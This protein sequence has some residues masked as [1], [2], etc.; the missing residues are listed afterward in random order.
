V[1]LGDRIALA[2]TQR[3]DVEQAHPGAFRDAQSPGAFAP[4][5]FAQR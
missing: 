5:S 3:A 4:R 1:A 2:L